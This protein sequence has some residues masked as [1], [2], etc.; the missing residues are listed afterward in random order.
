M[1]GK[2]RIIIVS[3]LTSLIL[4]VAGLLLCGC[5]CI[6]CIR[7]LVN[8]FITATIEGKQPSQIQMTQIQ[9]ETLPLMCEND[10]M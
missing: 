5:C 6:P 7:S 9:K 3:V 1:F 2:W 4:V 10:E 8:R